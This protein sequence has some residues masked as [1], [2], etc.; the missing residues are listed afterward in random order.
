MAGIGLMV[1]ACADAF[2]YHFGAW[3]ALDMNGK[4][5]EVVAAFVAS[6]EV[7]TEFITCLTRFGR[8]FGGFGMLVFGFGLLKW[9]VLPGY[10]GG[11]AVLIGLSAMAL[12]MGLPDDLHLYTPVFHLYALWLLS[13][14]VVTLRTGLRAECSRNSPVFVQR[15]HGRSKPRWFRKDH[16]DQEAAQDRNRNHDVHKTHQRQDTQPLGDHRYP[17]LAVQP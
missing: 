7:S 14:G 8:V 1:G 10:I 3:G 16:I 6:L 15:L 11:V 5:A 9:E 12:T 17:P 4:S 2:Y 13:T